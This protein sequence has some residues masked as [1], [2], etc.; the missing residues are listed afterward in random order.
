LYFFLLERKKNRAHDISKG[1]IEKESPSTSTL[2]GRFEKNLRTRGQLGLVFV[3]ISRCLFRWLLRQR[4]WRS[5][6]CLL[7]LRRRRHNCQV[8]SAESPFR[9]TRRGIERKKERKKDR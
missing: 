7:R 1:G 9:Q 2:S 4:W 6:G 3:Y 8:S 5:S